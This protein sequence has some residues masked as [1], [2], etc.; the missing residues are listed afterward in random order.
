MVSKVL[1][2]GELRGFTM[3]VAQRLLRTPAT[4]LALMKDN[5]NQAED[6]PQRRQLLF[7]SELANQMQATVDIAD[8][9]R[10]KAEAAG[11]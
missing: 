9:M 3:G 4:V 8:R 5:L 10:R 11:S 7:A 2:A 6:D 1:P